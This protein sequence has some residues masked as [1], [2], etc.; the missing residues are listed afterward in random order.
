MY[1]AGCVM[2]DQESPTEN[3]TTVPTGGG[4]DRTWFIQVVS[5][6]CLTAANSNLVQCNGVQKAL[7]SRCTIC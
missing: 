1:T 3:L 4:E 6:I 7:S 5:F 2:T